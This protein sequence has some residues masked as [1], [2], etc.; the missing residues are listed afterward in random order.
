MKLVNAMVFS[1]LRGVP[2]SI[3]LNVN[4]LKPRCLWTT[5]I[6]RSKVTTFKIFLVGREKDYEMKYELFS[7]ENSLRNRWRS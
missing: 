4:L 7:K 3:Q 5:G 1:L 2:L 6:F